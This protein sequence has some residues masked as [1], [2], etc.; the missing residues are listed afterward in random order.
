MNS[1]YASIYNCFLRLKA[2]IV[3]DNCY[4]I[5]SQLDCEQWL[6]HDEIQALQLRRFRNILKNAAVNSPYY[7]KKLS[8]L[9][10]SYRDIQSIND[11]HQIPLLTR[12]ELQSHFREILCE[13]AGNVYADSS[14]G[15][16]GQPVNF[17]HDSSY[18]RYANAVNLLFYKWMDI[19]PGMKTAAFWGADREFNELSMNEKF[20]YMHTRV[21]LYNFFNVTEASLLKFLQNMSNYKPAY[22]YGYAS[23]LKMAAEYINNSE[24]SFNISPKAIRSSAEILFKS[25]RHEIETAFN[26]PLF[27]FYG[28]RE[29]NNLGSECEYHKGMHIFSSGRLME[30]VDKKGNP[31]PDGEN[32]FI[33][34]TDLTNMN[35][36]FI[37]YMN[38]DM[39]VI[40]KNQCT[41]GR[42]YPLLKEITGR[43]AEILCINGKYVH[44]EFFT[45]LFYGMPEVRQFQVIQ[46]TDNQIRIR[47]VAINR[48]IDIEGIEKKIETQI[49]GK[50][51]IQ[52]EYVDNIAPLKSG[53]YQLIINN[54]L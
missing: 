41:C 49:N 16:T 29:I 26:A 13:N 40:D 17:Y 51:Q 2:T 23:A 25:Q 32:G 1:L 5:Y 24:L 30:I 50:I 19:E 53:K 34:V 21:R 47:I 14:G 48:D 15:S 27:N 6:N 38:G 54:T 8:D 35:F 46:E 52:I 43:A 20:W 9:K 11:I 31:V 37:R 42:G 18:I 22:I 33:V 36:P 44:G 28:S 7:R 4:R 45:H 12:S 39:G 10:V 3:G